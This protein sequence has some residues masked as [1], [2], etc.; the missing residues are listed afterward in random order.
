MEDEKKESSD[1]TFAEENKTEESSVGTLNAEVGTVE[2]SGDA[3][4]DNAQE[5]TSEVENKEGEGMAVDDAD[6]ERK[7][8]VDGKQELESNNGE[9]NG[10]ENVEKDE[11][12]ETETTDPEII[13]KSFENIK[14][15]EEPID[16]PEEQLEEEQFD[17]SKV[18]IK[19]EPVEPEP[20][21]Y[22]TFY[23]INI[24]NVIFQSIKV[25]PIYCT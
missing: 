17:F 21:M 20:G 10:V 12:K 5:E 6:N 4:K 25:W 7:D 23:V 15:K 14:I 1:E 9:T 8:T 18:E 24:T 22:C 11:T 2:T 13:E 16:E 3:A 19:A